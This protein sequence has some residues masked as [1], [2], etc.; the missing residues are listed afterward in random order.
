MIFL[1]SKF[2]HLGW[3]RRAFT[4]E[5]ISRICRRE[6]I[7]LVEYPLSGSPGSYMR[8]G[9]RS[10]IAVDSRLRGVRRL[11]VLLHELGHHLLHVPPDATVAYFFQLKPD[12]KQEHEAE[13]FAAV[14]L[15][16]EPLLRRLLAEGSDFDEA[17]FTKDVVE[18]RLKVLDLYGI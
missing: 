6:K 5:D 18:F 12:S 16:P 3:N 1:L 8:V 10:V 2:E 13:V 7:E 4:E 15:L 17:G 11:Y 9:G 14:A